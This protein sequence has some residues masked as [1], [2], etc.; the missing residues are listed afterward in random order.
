MHQMVD[1]GTEF[2]ILAELTIEL[3][4]TLA[5]ISTLPRRTPDFAQ[6]PPEQPYFIYSH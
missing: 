1:G 4:K 6:L 5:S 3:E 2:G